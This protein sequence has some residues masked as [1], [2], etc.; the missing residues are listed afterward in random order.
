M[1]QSRHR[2]TKINKSC[3]IPTL[4]LL[5][6]DHK[7]WSPT[8][9]TPP[10]A[11]PVCAANSGM[12]VHF[13]DLLSMVL[14]PLAS[15]VPGSW[16]VISVDDFISGCEDYNEE[17]ENKEKTPEAAGGAGVPEAKVGTGG[18]GTPKKIKK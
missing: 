15:T 12:N 7:T 4:R 6:K 1:H 3:C 16:E 14:E 8:D 11:R 10:P 18:E 5:F 17:L 2:E 9:G 13:S